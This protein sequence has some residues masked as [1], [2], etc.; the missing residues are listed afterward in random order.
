MQVH[1]DAII[2]GAGPSG[3][4]AAILLAQAGWSVALLEKQSFP[5]RKVCGECIAASNL[6]LLDALGIGDAFAR[7]AG[8]ELH[9][10]ALWSGAQSISAALP[11]VRDGQHP[12]GRAL[13]REH[14]DL[15][16]LQRAKA[17]GVSVLQPCTARSLG[18]RPGEFRCEA[19]IADGE[20]AI[21]LRAPIAIA[22]YGSWQCLPADRAGRRTKQRADDLLAFKA[23]FG[24][25]D[26]DEGL[27]PVL[28]FRG[29]YGGMVVAD[30]GITTVAC[31]I[32]A[33]RL[34]AC[35]Q[36]SPGRRPAR[37]WKRI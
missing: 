37:S 23:N 6:P 24:N 2:V 19:L 8:P 3:S 15:L 35:R 12:W 20:C 14:L 27:L 17:A 18:G 33:D 9:R 29:G 30:Q 16:L 26:L 34:K 10:V 4:T 1:Y 25:V 22:A 7:M 21:T 31:C 11:G 32:R 5:R 36:Q 28:A 13:G